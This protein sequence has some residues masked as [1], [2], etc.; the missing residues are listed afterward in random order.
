MVTQHPDHAGKPYWHNKTYISTRHEM[1][2]A[3]LSFSE[4]GATEYKWDWEGKL[5]DESVLERFLGE[6]LE[7]LMKK[8]L[9]KENFI[10][11]RLPNPRIATE[12]RLGRTFMNMISSAA[13]AKHLGFKVPPIFEVILPMT[14]NAREMLDLQVAFQ[15]LRNLK[16]PLFKMES[17]LTNLRII[18]LFESVERIIDSAKIVEE[19]LDLYKKEFGKLPPYMRPYFARSDPALNS[20]VVATVFA[21]KIALSRFRKLEQRIGIPFYPMIGCG[22]LP[23]R[24]GLTPE[25]VKEFAN[26]YQGVR[27]VTLQSAFRYDYPLPRVKKAIKQLA[28]ILPKQKARLITENDE[29]ELIAIGKV[30][31]KEYKK[32]VENLAVAI[33]KVSVFVPKRRER[34]QHVGLFGYSRGDGKVKLPRAI[35]FTASLYSIGIPP[36]LIGTG[37][38]LALAKKAGKL[39]L[40]EKYYINLKKDLFRAGSYL[41]KA[42][43]T[44]LASASNAWKDVAKDVEEV[45]RYLGVGLGPHTVNEKKHLALTSRIFEGVKKSSADLSNL[46]TQAAVLRKSLG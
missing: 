8:P 16:H 29:K 41:N 6:H 35:T 25:N 30:F 2:E 28:E 4:L 1:N 40:V 43:L 21:L 22:S 20:G 19:Y 34:V 27:T 3:F 17:F 38:G 39:D 12:F 44:K 5:V 7:Y 32:T 13:T 11:F 31:E 23:F 42:N 37:R 33:N 45:E 26:A 10:T 14:E 18:P 46:M 15:E 24:G 36:E 9:G